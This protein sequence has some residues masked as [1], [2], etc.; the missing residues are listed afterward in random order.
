MTRSQSI[1]RATTAKAIQ[2]TRFPLSLNKKIQEDLQLITIIGRETL[3][4]GRDALATPLQKRLDFLFK[5][6]EE[7]SL[8]KLPERFTQNEKVSVNI[9]RLLELVDEYEALEPIPL[10]DRRRK[11]IEENIKPALEGLYSIHTHLVKMSSPASKIP[12]KAIEKSLAKTSLRNECKDTVAALTFLLE[13]GKPH[14]YKRFLSRLT[15]PRATGAQ[16]VG[17]AME[18]RI[19]LQL[20]HNSRLEILDANAQVSETFNQSNRIEFFDIIARDNHT[21]RIILFEIKRDNEY[22]LG[23][24]VYQFLGI[25]SN[26][27]G[28][29]RKVVSQIDVLLDSEKFQLPS[30]CAEDIARGNYEVRVLTHRELYDF[31]YLY[32]RSNRLERLLNYLRQPATHVSSAKDTLRTL[33][34]Q[35]VNNGIEYLSDKIANQK[36]ELAGILVNF[37]VINIR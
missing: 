17:T 32:N 13:Q 36:P 18:L 3:L 35:E 34:K 24:F 26:K 10:N 21:D 20:S 11:K 25:G 9:D 7:L 5:Y 16:I 12:T 31:T 27:Q 1:A 4:R 37:S 22:T 30:S 19:I 2:Q 23:D 33:T 6:F 14:I 29:K 15:D 28:A 8:E